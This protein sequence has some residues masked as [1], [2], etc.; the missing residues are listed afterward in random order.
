MENIEDIDPNARQQLFNSF[1][2]AALRVS[3]DTGHAHYAHSSNGAP[4]VDYF[5]QAAG[6]LL[7]HV[8]L[9]NADGCADRHWALVEGNVG[10]QAV[11]RA[12]GELAHKPRLV[13]E[14]PNKVGIPASMRM[15]EAAG[16]AE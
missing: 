16:L 12:L 8:L 13:L 14:L 15:L 9:Q 11:F 2:S 6:S 5:D 10:W 1:N 4:P 3:I 7:E